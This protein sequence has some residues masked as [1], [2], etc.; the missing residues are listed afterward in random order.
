VAAEDMVVELDSR[1]VKISGRRTEIP[2]EPEMRFH[3][4]EIPY[5]A[6]ERVVF[7]PAPIDPERVSAFYANGLLRLCMPKR[8][9]EIPLRVEIRP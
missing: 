4:A 1:A 5:G 3:L 8:Q 2:R 7:L 9:K 6:F